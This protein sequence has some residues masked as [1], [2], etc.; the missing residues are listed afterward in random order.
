MVDSI[1]DLRNVSYT[2]L[3]R[4]EALKEVNLTINAG[5]AGCYPRCKRERQI[6]ASCDPQLP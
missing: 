3:R 4:F 5:R 2:Y 1:F 6:D